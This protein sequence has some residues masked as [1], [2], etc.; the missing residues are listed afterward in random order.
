MLHSLFVYFTETTAARRQGLGEGVVLWTFID[1]D[2]MGTEMK[3]QK[4]PRASNKI[5]TNRYTKN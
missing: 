5:Q 3:T 2:R 1:G 4:I